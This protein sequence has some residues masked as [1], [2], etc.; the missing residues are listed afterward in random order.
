MRAHGTSI[1]TAADAFHFDDVRAEIAEDHA[2]RG[3]GHD[4]AQV[5]YANAL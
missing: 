5:K 4:G 3:P 1:V 2:G